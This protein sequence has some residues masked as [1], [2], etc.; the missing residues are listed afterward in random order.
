M[1]REITGQRNKALEG[2]IPSG[3]DR[4]A[5]LNRAEDEALALIEDAANA[6]MERFM[7]KITAMADEGAT[8]AEIEKEVRRTI[9]SRSAW[10]KRVVQG[11]V[12][13]ASE[14]VRM[15]VATNSGRKM[16]KY[17]IAQ[18]DDRVRKWHRKAHGQRRLGGSRFRVG[19]AWLRYPGDPQAPLALT[20]HCRCWT[21]WSLE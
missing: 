15:G 18:H 19:P 9:G 13:R 10:R 6:Q 5:I 11:A 7:D 2:L 14:G 12:Q 4:A 21:H 17:W 16:V 8:L 1:A 3:I 20:I